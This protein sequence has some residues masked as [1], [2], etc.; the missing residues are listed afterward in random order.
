YS[1]ERSRYFKPAD[2]AARLLLFVLHRPFLARRTF[3]LLKRS[4]PLKKKILTIALRA[5][6]ENPLSQLDKLRLLAGI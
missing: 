4:R 5:P 1:L 6:A 3:R 2:Q